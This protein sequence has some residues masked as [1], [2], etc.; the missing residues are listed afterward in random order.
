M[1]RRQEKLIGPT[2]SCDIRVFFI[3]WTYRITFEAFSNFC[4]DILLTPSR[5]VT[6][7]KMQC[8]QYFYD[9]MK[10]HPSKVK[11]CEN[12]E[13]HLHIYTVQ[14]TVHSTL[15][16]VHCTLHWLPRDPSVHPRGQP[17]SAAP[18][19]IVILV[20]ITT[21]YFL[22]PGLHCNGW[23]GELDLLAGQGRFKM[24]WDALRQEGK[25]S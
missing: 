13:A 15:Y 16:T 4:P 7:P 1:V 23:A 11:Y 8:Q 20:T 2:F 21:M 5:L 10:S 24:W 17:L 22:L 14:Y 12:S 6:V 18:S 3:P 25:S 19:I 9:S